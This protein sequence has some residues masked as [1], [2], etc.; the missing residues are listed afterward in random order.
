MGVNQPFSQ[1]GLAHHDVISSNL[2]TC[3]KSYG[4]AFTIGRL[5]DVISSGTVVV[6][7]IVGINI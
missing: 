4:I 3:C 2:Y 1:V 6:V 5:P 7:V